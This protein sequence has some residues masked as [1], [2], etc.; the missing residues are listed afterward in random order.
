MK[1]KNDIEAQAGFKDAGGDL[2]VAGQLLSSTGTETNWIDQSTIASG[3]AEVVEVPVKNLQG[4]ALTKGD[5]VYISGSVGASGILEVQLADASNAAKMPAVGLL[6]QDLAINAE[7]FAVVTGKLRN[8][9]TSP[10]DG[11]TPNPNTVIYV[12][13]G[14]STG[15]A[16]TTVKPGGSTNL[17]QNVGKVGRVSTSSDGT[18][19][20][21]SILRSNDVPN[22]PLGRLF[23][24]TSAN[25]SL[26]SDVVYIDDAND[27]VGI[28]TT[29]PTAALDVKN[30]VQIDLDGTYGGSGYSA[31]GFGGLINGYPRIFGHPSLRTLYINSGT[32]GAIYFRTNGTSTA[33]MTMA[34]SGNVGI[35]TTSPQQRLQI[36]SP[37]D[38][39]VVLGASYSPT[40]NSNFFEI[41][42]SAND[43]YL[44]LRNSGVATTVHI[45]S[46]NSS[47]FN[48]G[49]VGIGTTSP[50]TKLH[51]SGLTGDDDP[52]LGSSTA[53]LFVSNTANS[54]GLNIGVNSTGASWLQA[55]SNTSAIA[56]D[57]LLN[58]LDGNVGIGTTSPGNTLSIAGGNPSTTTLGTNFGQFGI[59]NNLGQYGIQQWVAG[60]GNGNI[61]VGRIDGTATAYNLILQGLGGN[62]GIRTTSPTAPLHIDGGTT[63]EVLKVEADTSPYIRWV[64]NGTNVGFLQFSATNAYLSNM[65]NGSFF[66]RT[67]NTDRMIITSVGNV[68]VGTTSP[69]FKLDVSGDGIRNIRSTAGWAGWFE[70]TASSSGVVITAG[71]DSGDAPLLVRKQDATE[72]FSVRGNGVSWFNGG[73]VG[74]GTTNPQEELH[75]ASTVPVIRIEDTDGGYAQIVGSNGSLSLRADQANTVASSV[76]DFTIDNSEKMRITSTGNVGIGTTSPGERLTVNSNG[77]TNSVLKINALDNRGA[78]R[79]ALQIDDNDA[80]SR[81]SLYIDT[82]TGPSIITTGN[83]GIN[84]TA[85]TEKLAVTGNIETTEAAS[86]VKIGFNV[87][88]S[89]TLNGADTAH[90]G[91]S[92]GNSTSVPLVLS[93]YYG[94]AIATSGLERVRILQSNGYVGIGTTSPGFKLD[95]DNP[96]VSGTSLR[97]KSISA[98]LQIE[99][100][101]AG[102]A[103]IYFLPN[104][105]GTQSAAFR[106]TN[107]Y[108]FAFRNA[109]G[110]EYLTIK[111][112]SGRVGVN[113]SAPAYELDVTGTIRATGDLYV[114]GGDIILDGTGRIQGVDTVSA[115]TD[116]VN[117]N[118]VDNNFVADADTLWSFD[119]DGAG[120]AQSVTVGNSVWF[121][122]IN[123][124]TFTSQTGPVGFEHQ[125]GASLDLTG[126][127]AGSY[128][129][130]NI[131]VDAYGRISAASNGTGGGGGGSVINTLIS[132]FYHSTN[133][134]GAAYYLPFNGVNELP[135]TQY[136]NNF[137]APYS[138][139]VKKMIIKFVTGPT[140][141]ATSF[142]TFR[143]LINGS[144]FDFTP[145]TTGGGT[146]SMKGVYTFANNDA[147]FSEGDSI[148]FGFI[149]SGGTGFLYGCAA[150]TLIEYT[151]I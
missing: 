124:I 103:S 71:T 151:G 65:S 145:T 30:L 125:V 138:G 79:Y 59:F 132:S 91:L 80:N 5:P 28:G 147:T 98:Q 139:R 126:V 137:I 121:E 72:I 3:S 1:F 88:D 31:I 27:R 123:G 99:S 21:S 17:I 57:I 19:V 45:D 61:Q 133:V 83:V 96:S 70:N 102:D 122:G 112:A 11:V 54:Y 77:S 64:Q 20:V 141:T 13:S 49:N 15:A 129:N 119:A 85:P 93:G 10:I 131:T 109:T 4:S 38:T 29:S 46:D 111:T 104:S 51:V 69:S 94:V 53:P 130:A 144:S 84:T 23:V 43:G 74:I 24:G 114:N 148:Q 22:L 26:T 66:F 108:N 82:L 34:T 18:L 116:A 33:V 50:R 40:N 81:G 105:L 117:K 6:K 76:I 14:G 55:Q 12:K 101:T 110:T 143:I 95:L 134:S 35:G 118:Y 56:Y 142:S 135:S 25:T 100:N 62:V 16:L 86:G 48:G 7:G 60:T 9:V 90:Y 136:Y 42:I 32:G 47:Y 149:T 36:A 52:A 8:L 89:F 63:S 128:T 68:G 75:I 58:P 120:T 78:S 115:G 150:T 140:P 44:N 127:S 39:S 146:S 41:G 92:C 73:N 67:A 37:S 106:V 87:G 113:Q 2:G 107:G 97:I